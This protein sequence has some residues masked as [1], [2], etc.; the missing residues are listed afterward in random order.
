[1]TVLTPSGRRTVPAS[2]LRV[3]D[4]VVLNKDQRVPADLLLLRTSDRSGS[5]FIRT[6]QLDGETDWKLRYVLSERQSDVGL[7]HAHLAH[8]FSLQG[9]AGLALLWRRRSTCRR[10]RR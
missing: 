6:D 7:A 3:G 1:M 5:C 10:T 4:L 8:F 2:A 9:C